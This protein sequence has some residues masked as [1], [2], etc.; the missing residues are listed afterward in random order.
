MSERVIDFFSSIISSRELVVFV[1]SMLPIVELRGAIPLAVFQF[2]FDILKAFL[3][4]VGGNLLIVVPLVFLM[5]LAE[6]HFRKYALLDRWMSRLF[7]RAKKRGGYVEKYKSLGLFLFVAIPLPGTGAWTGALVA[8]LLSMD[9]KI[10]FISIALGVVM[11]GL[12]VTF[13]T[14]LGLWKGLLLAVLTLFVL[15][16]VLTVILDKF[17]SKA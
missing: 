7:E 14:T 16:R 5:D 13:F 4:S 1:V 6:K 11:A 8:Y 15:D 2:K 12:L 17:Y 3:L 9:K 10:A